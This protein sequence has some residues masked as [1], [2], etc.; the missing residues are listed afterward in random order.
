[1]GDLGIHPIFGMPGRAAVDIGDEALG[2][3][4]GPVQPALQL[5]A[6]GGGPAKIRGGDVGPVEVL[7]GGKQQGAGAVRRH[8][9]QIMRG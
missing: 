2:G 9:D 6:I 5:C 8:D 4:K 3:A 7:Q 1:M